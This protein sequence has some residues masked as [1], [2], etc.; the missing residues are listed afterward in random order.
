MELNQIKKNKKV[1][2]RENR[3]ARRVRQIDGES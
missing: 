3:M 1:D 2:K